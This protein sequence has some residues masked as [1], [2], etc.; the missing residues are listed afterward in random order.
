MS[1]GRSRSA[2]TVS[3]RSFGVSRNSYA[4]SSDRGSGGPMMMGG[5][6]PAHL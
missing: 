4:M 5:K 2:F 3:V 1:A 6:D